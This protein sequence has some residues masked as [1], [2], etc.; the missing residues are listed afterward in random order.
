MEFMESGLRAR[1]RARARFWIVGASTIALAFSAG[2]ARAQETAATSAQDGATIVVTGSRLVT[3]GMESPV[4]VTAVQ[5]EELEAMDPGALIN[6]VS[7]LP[8]FYGNSTPNNSNF[9]VRGGTGN[10]NLRGLGANRTLTLLNGRRVPSTSAFGGVDINLFPEAMI[11]GIETVTGGASAAYGTDAVAGVVNFLLNTNFEGIEAGLQGGITERGDGENYEAK[12]AFGTRIGDRGHLLVAASRAEQDGIHDLTSR[13]WYQGWGAVQVGGVWA[14]YPH[15]HSISASFD[16]IISAPGTV[17]NGLAFNRDGGY[18]PFQL[19]SPS[20]G[21]V[22]GAGPAAGRAS[23]GGGDDLN[24]EAFTLYPDTDRYSIFAYGDYEVSDNVTLFAQYMRGYNH[25]FQYNTP[26]SSLYGSPTAITIFQDNAFLPESLRTLMQE[27]DIPSFSLRRA[28][29]LEDIGDV[30]FEDRTTQNVGTAGFK[31]NIASGGFLD[32]WQVN[33]YY[34]YGRSRR[35][36]DQY[37][38]RVDRI[39]AAVDAVEDE[40]GNVVCRVSTFAGGAA[41]FPGC[42]PINLFGRGNASAA[43]VDYV[44]GND[45]GQHVDTPLYFANLGYIGE[46][47]SYDAV[48]P[49]R[50]ITTFQQHFAEVSAH[51]E[52]FQLPAGAVSLAIGASYRKESIRQIVQDTT[53]QPSNHDGGVRPVMCNNAEIGLRGVNGADCANTVGFQFSKVSNIQGEADVKEAFAET[54]IPLFDD[55]AGRSATLNLSGRWADYSG[56]GTIWAYKGGIDISL[57]EDVR[58]RGTYSRDVRAGNLSERFDKTGGTGNVLDPRTGAQNATWAGQTYQ[59]T[60]FSGGN[61]AIKPESADTFTAGVVFQPVFAPGLSASV[62]WYTV[63]ISDAIATVGTNE[64][65]RRCF[66]EN[67][68]QFCSLVTTDPAQDGKIILVGNQY[69]NVAQSRVQGVDAELGYRSDVR[70]L[71]GDEQLGARVFLSWLLDR[72][73]VGATGTVTRFDGLTGLA[74]DTGAQGLFPKLKIT[75]NVNYRN[76]PFSAFLQGRLIGQGTRTFLFGPA[77]AVEGVNIADNS[78]PAVFYADLRLSYDLSLLGAETQIWGSVTNLFDRAPP[79]T[80]T[81]STFTG[82]SGQYN[83]GLFDVLGRRFTVGVKLRM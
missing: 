26:R 61:P 25:Q 53:N 59:V 60:I 36:W 48:A 71:G 11:S 76:G 32:G 72:S 79:I 49:K 80:G 67:D 23:G 54:L 42:Q 22:G 69:V 9:F 38:L 43:A 24:G 15:V 7:Q 28:G 81:Y 16:G 78:V 51:G 39:F 18:A 52:L 64:V 4:P 30:W 77:P 46:T 47:L 40:G 73:D 50:N 57:T 3:N 37:S 35:V 5:A 65:A 10:L 45:V 20:Q 29:S 33:G 14:D 58:L 19:G 41:A 44:M 21:V 82:T 31:A 68:P 63:N 66:A 1:R 62:D 34:Q 13:D 55:G 70:L 27:N 75:G 6:S 56:S 8:Q 74:P 83:A 17:I 2:A 12:L